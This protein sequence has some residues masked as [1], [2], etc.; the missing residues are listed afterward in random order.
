MVINIK[1]K[2]E[3]GTEFQEKLARELL[4]GIMDTYKDELEK[5]H[6]KNKLVITI[7]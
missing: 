7:K 3:F 6:Y 2:A 5:N 4:R 1:I